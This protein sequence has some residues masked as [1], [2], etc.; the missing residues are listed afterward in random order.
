MKRVQLRKMTSRRRFLLIG[1][2]FSVLLLAAVIIGLGTLYRQL[3]TAFLRQDQFVPTRVYSDLS[4]LSPGKVT[5]RWTEAI[6]KTRRYPYRVLDSG[7]I[8]QFKLRKIDYPISLLPPDH[9]TFRASDQ[10]IVLQFEP[11]NPAEPKK[12]PPLLSVRLGTEELGGIFLEPELVAQLGTGAESRPI[13]NIVHLDE[14][15]PQL[16]KA[17]IAIED[18]HFLEHKGLD[19]KGMARALWVNLKTFS[20]SQ[21]GST[22]TAQ[23]VKN[24][25]ERRGKNPFRKAAELLLSLILETRFNKEEILERYLNEVYLGQSGAFEVHGVAEGAELFFGR[26]LDELNLAEMALMAGLIRGPAFY[27]PYRHADRAKERMGLVLKKMVETGKLSAAEAKTALKLPIR[28]APLQNVTLRAPYFV[29]YV[30]AELEKNFIAK[31]GNRNLTDSGLRVYTTLDLHLNNL[32]Q[33]AIARG[34]EQLTKKHKLPASQK[35]EGALASVDQ[36]TGQI[37]ALVGGSSYSKSTFNRILNMKRQVGSTF[38][39]VVFLSAFIKKVDRSGIPFGGGYFAPDQPWTLEYDE[40]RQKWKPRNY[41]RKYLGWISLRTALSQSINTVTARLAYEVG[42]DTVVQTAQKLG[43]TSPLPAVPSLALGSAELS[44]LEVLRIY[45]TLANHGKAEEFSVVKLITE[46]NGAPLAHFEPHSTQAVEPGAADLITDFLQ[47][48]MKDGTARFTPS[49]GFHHP[50][51]GKTGTTNN[52]RDS[53]FAG[54]TPHLTTVA[55]V[56]FDQEDLGSKAPKFT[57]ATA[58]LPIW[59]DYMREA[60]VPLPE[61]PFPPSSELVEITIDSHSGKRPTLFCPAA[62]IVSEKYLKENVPQ[63]SGC[64]EHFPQAPNKTVL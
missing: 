41:E 29:D 61:T 45:A 57:G 14:T 8:I 44:P 55:W 25:M 34:V 16:W 11:K 53:W 6:L 20:F 9:P 38:K 33:K 54:F 15:P 37:R 56:G 51:A 30:K 28:L 58:A 59:A 49:L 32:A 24:L 18:Q 5:R 12:D 27:S 39:P 62:Q 46:P 3:E 42:I 50:A 21:G 31:L 17:I 2:T 35:V 10:E 13:R 7:Q 47:S 64:D 26:S 43:V 1:V 4:L 19:P 40:G 22:L 60:H 52:Y 63:S 48:V 36:N 23:L